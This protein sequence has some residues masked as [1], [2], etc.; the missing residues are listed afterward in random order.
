MSYTQEQ[1]QEAL[2]QQ[3]AN[4]QNA[5]V[6]YNPMAQR[7]GGQH[8]VNDLRGAN[9]PPPPP[10][11]PD[12]ERVRDRV[13]ALADSLWANND[14]FARLYDR[15]HGPNPDAATGGAAPTPAGLLFQINE[16][17][18]RIDAAAIRGGVLAGAFERFA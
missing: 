5:H 4:Y 11:L 17:L 7:L 9:V 8:S 3:Q 15:I 1:M 16:A 13:V 12:L 18:D 6:G 10:E 14:R 2:K